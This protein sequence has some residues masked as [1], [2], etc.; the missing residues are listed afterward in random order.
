MSMSTA[1]SSQYAPLLEVGQIVLFPNLTI[2]VMCIVYGFY[3]ALFCLC[4]YV[5]RNVE[6][7][8]H[9]WPIIALFLLSTGMVLEITYELQKSAVAFTSTK[10]RDFL[11]LLDYLT[12][13]TLRTTVAAFILFLPISANVIADYI[14]VHRCYI[15]WGSAKTILF[16]LVFVSFAVNVVYSTGAIMYVIGMRDE[17]IGSNLYWL[18]EGLFIQA[19]GVISSA[20]FNFILTLLTAGRIWWITR[21]FW[22]SSWTF[23]MKT[24]NKIIIESGILYPCTTIIHLAVTNAFSAYE[25]PFDTFPPIVLAAGIA[26]TLLVVRARLGIGDLNDSNSTPPPQSKMRFA[27]VGPTEGSFSRLSMVDRPELSSVM[28]GVHVKALPRAHQ[29]ARTV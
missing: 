26:P 24:I 5:Q 22:S 13:D 29:E 8:G 17:T 4:M 12:H 18:K 9:V 21:G 14:L 3:I 20:S 2:M 15:I 19:V 27:S 25:I 11:P 7:R 28:E 16:P 10:T 23:A 1:D 6:L